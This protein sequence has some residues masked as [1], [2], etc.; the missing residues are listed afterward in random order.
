[1]SWAEVRAAYPEQWLVVE[2]LEAHTTE[3]L[4]ILDK[5]AVVETCSDGAVAFKRYRELRG[6][7]PEREWCFVHT[8]N[9][10]LEIV[11]RD[12][13]S[14]RPADR[15]RTLRGVGGVE[16]V[17][18]RRIERFAV[19]DHGIADFEIEIGEMVNSADRLIAR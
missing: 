14:P 1:M 12:R 16:Y 3:R 4:R 13:H 11:D 19:G 6:A 10:E 2:A 7:R 18:V 9:V 5:I 8:A 15:L 17:F